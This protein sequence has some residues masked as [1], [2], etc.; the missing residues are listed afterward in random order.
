MKTQLLPLT[1]ILPERIVLRKEGA[2]REKRAGNPRVLC[3]PLP[4]V[5]GRLGQGSSWPWGRGGALRGSRRGMSPQGWLSKC[6]PAVGLPP[7]CSHGHPGAGLQGM[8]GHH[9]PNS[10]QML[11]QWGAGEGRGQGANCFLYVPGDLS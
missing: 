5:L 3:R 6:V 2:W 7:V 8:A 9:Q 10:L 1:T 11:R 4:V